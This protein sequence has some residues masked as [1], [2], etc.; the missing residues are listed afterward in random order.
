MFKLNGNRLPE[1]T[2]FKD[3]EGNQYPQNWLNLSTEEEKNA[4]GITW[5]ADPTRADDRFYWDGNISNPKALEDVLATDDNGDP[6]YVQVWDPE[7]ETMVDTSEQMVTKGL[8][9][10]WIAQIKQTTNLLLAQSDWYVIRK[11]ERDVA[12]P[13]DTIT[14]RA[15]I[16][17]E[18][19]RLETAITSATTVT[20]LIEVLNTQNWPK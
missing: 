14:K 1:G 19:N 20:G 15:A 9:T 3:A 5:E 17:T 6:V 10:N 2:A 12:I 18:S 13:T 8:K 16:I 7:T 11:A 4:I